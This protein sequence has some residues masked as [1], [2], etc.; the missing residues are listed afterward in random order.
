MVK[1]PFYEQASD[2][3]DPGY[4]KG[5]LLFIDDAR[6]DVNSGLDQ[7][8]VGSLQY[9]PQMARTIGEHLDQHRGIMNTYTVPVCERGNLAAAAGRRG[10]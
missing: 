2:A 7:L 6:R 8:A 9:V 3:A 5:L 10:H 1:C 4:R